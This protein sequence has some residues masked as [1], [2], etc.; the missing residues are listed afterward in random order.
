MRIGITGHSNLTPETVALVAE[1]PRGLLVGVNQPVVGVTCLA[2]GA[3]QVFARVVL[4]LGGD[5]EVVLPASDYRSRKVKPDNAAEFDDLIGK[6][7]R[8]ACRSRRPTEMPTWLPASSCSPASTR[9]WRYGT[10]NLP[11]AT[12]APGT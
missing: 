12:A 2:R 5:I 8:V 3:D 10:D 11:T 6:A 7:R 4:E 1:A 9:W